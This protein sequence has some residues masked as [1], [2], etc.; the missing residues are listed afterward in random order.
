[1]SRLVRVTRESATA[2]DAPGA[3]MVTAPKSDPTSDPATVPAQ[4]TTA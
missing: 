1:M 3:A 2:A 4:V